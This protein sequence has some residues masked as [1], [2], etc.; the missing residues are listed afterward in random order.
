MDATPSHDS[1]IKPPAF[2]LFA[3]GF[4]PF[5]LAAGVYAL[6]GLIAWLW[7]YATGVQPMPNQPAQLWHGH[8][9]L[10]GFVGAAIAGFLLTAVP[11]WTSAR[12]FAGTPL[13][14]LA[15][16]WLAGRLAFAA[17][18]VLPVALVAVCELAFIP[19]LGALLAPPLL[20]ARN[21]NSPLLLVLASIWLTDAVF[22]YAL[23][24]DDVLLAR[25]TLLVAIDIVLLLVTVIGGRIVPAFTANA[26]RA[27][28][29]ATDLRSSRWTDGI[30]IGAM[31]AVVFVDII[32]SWHPV[33]G[34]VAAVAAI[35][36]VW[37]L[38]GWRSW[39]T[40]DEPL[41]W[42]LHLAYA[43]LPVGLA[44]KA[45]YL[46]GSV[47]CAAHWLHALTIGVAAAMI[48]AVMTRASLGH[49]GRPLL[50]SRLIG[51][52]YILLSLAAVMRV[53]A[54][55]LAPGAYQWSVMVAGTLWICAFAIFVVVY[56]PILL[57]PRIDGRQG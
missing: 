44:M 13:I 57:R 42:S 9:M 43:W 5:F 29:R 41:V 7:I 3:Y 10:Y 6:V 35:T 46:A 31:I 39:R 53:L 51:G 4:R 17:A 45:M 37:R 22:M 50:A 34:G 36:H 32:A 55:P 38:I 8:E 26:L 18:A 15:A 28:G 33:A 14:M 49:T 19:A 1:P 2:A 20:R 52:A 12:G 16:L 30:L 54:P 21:R 27:R 24:R 40:L 47:A 56:R 11:S 23:M 48:L 25:T